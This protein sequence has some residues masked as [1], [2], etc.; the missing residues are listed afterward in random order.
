[1]PFASRSTVKTLLTPLHGKI[2]SVFEGA[3]AEVAVVEDCRLKHGYSELRYART[4]ADMIYDAMSNHV[5]EAFDDDPDVRVIH[6]AQ[7]FK[8]LFFANGSQPILAR[9]KK[10]D[11][12]GRG[13]NQPTQ[14]VMAFNDPE[15]VLPGFPEDAAC[16]DITYSHD[17][18]GMGIA[19]IFVLCRDGDQILWNYAIEEI[20]DTEATSDNVVTLPFAEERPDTDEGESL[21]VAKRDDKEKSTDD[22]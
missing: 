8:V 11:D 1:M 4:L 16:V 17:E 9:F 7:S 5:A 15:M 12:E 18:L 13:Q 21:V 3:R 22:E 14:T 10:G 20:S 2:R 6:E 19:D